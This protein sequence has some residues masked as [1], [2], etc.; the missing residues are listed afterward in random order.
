MKSTSS[1]QAL[2]NSDEV[3]F[4]TRPGAGGRWWSCPTTTI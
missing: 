4:V 1:L 3:T 2:S